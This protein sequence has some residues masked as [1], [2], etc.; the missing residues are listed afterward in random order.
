MVIF[1][2][3]LMFYFK[4]SG[5]FKRKLST[6]IAMVGNPPIVLLVSSY[7]ALLRIYFIVSKQSK[8]SGIYYVI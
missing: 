6:A 7:I 5:G 2:N 1:S 4:F 3:I 8:K